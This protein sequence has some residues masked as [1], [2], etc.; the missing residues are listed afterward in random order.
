M[1]KTGSSVSSKM[2]LWTWISD[3]MEANMDLST[4]GEADAGGWCK[5]TA[6]RGG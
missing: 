3:C 1:R 2:L 5:R 4:A 6:M